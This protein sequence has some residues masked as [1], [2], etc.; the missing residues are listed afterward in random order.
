MENFGTAISKKIKFTEDLRQ[1]KEEQG[2][3]KDESV[4]VNSLS[5]ITGLDMRIK[6]E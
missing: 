6:V 5:L 1:Q 4:A 3:Q 2:A